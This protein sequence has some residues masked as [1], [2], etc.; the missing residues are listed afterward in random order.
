MKEINY[1]KV[2]PLAIGAVVSVGVG[3]V[4]GTKSSNVNVTS[5]GRFE[6]SAMGVIGD[7]MNGNFF[8]WID[9]DNGRRFVKFDKIS[10]SKARQSSNPQPE[11]KVIYRNSNSTL[12]NDVR[13]GK[14]FE[15]KDKFKKGGTTF[16][17][18]TKIK[19]RGKEKKMLYRIA[20]SA[21]PQ[22][23]A[24]KRPLKCIT[25]RQESALLSIY[26]EKGSNAKLRFQD[27]DQFW[28]KDMVVPLN[29]PGANN[30]K[31]S[32]IDVNKD[33]CGKKSELIFHNR[34]N[35]NLPDFEWIDE[36]KLIFGGIK[37]KF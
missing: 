11:T 24:N 4:L 36:G 17:V 21:L 1:Q 29:P 25:A 19:Y 33:S 15:R 9:T 2:V 37:F 20:I 14:I 31:T 10:E 32:I 30:A 16:T 12:A 5:E 28:I 35:L 18:D 7:S 27:S 22:I 13:S 6:T 26:K 23:G 34:A 3:V 8:G